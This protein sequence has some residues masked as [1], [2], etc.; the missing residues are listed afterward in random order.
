MTAELIRVSLGVIAKGTLIPEFPSKFNFLFLFSI[1][2]LFK[3]PAY[4]SIE[5]LTESPISPL[6]LS[7]SLSLYSTNT[8]TYIHIYI[9]FIYLQT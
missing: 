8:L 6:S 4:P 7:L 1:K 2:R 9:N 3:S 5:R